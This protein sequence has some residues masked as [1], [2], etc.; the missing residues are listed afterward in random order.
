MT[1]RLERALRPRASV[2]LRGLCEVDLDTIAWEFLGSEFTGLTYADWPI[3]R[4]VN[5]FLAH[6]GMTD[7]RDNG[8][9]CVAVMQH[10]LANVGAALRDGTLPTATWE[11]SRRDRATKPTGSPR[12]QT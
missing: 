3:E 8:D 12:R 4:R 1:A 11:T 9:A 10:L 2:H 5:A 7:L 6:R